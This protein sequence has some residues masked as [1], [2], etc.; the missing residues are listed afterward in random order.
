MLIG[1]SPALSPVWLKAFVLELFVSNEVSKM[2][3]SI[4]L[5]ITGPDSADLTDHINT[6]GEVAV[7]GSGAIRLIGS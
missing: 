7:Y 6:S 1:L 2:P 3:K 4:L 5:F